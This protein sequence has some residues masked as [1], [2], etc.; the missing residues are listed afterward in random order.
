MVIDIASRKVMR[1]NKE[2]ALTTKE[3]VL[4]EYLARNANK[5]LSK[6]QLLE[7][8][9]EMTFDP[10]SNIVEVYMHQLRKKIDKG[11]KAQLIKTVVGAGYMLKGNKETV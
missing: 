8:A 9:W 10:E 6:N 4:L 2:I 1:D 7:N 3:F 11:F 5:V